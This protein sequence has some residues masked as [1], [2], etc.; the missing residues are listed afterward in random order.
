MGSSKLHLAGNASA[1]TL[2]STFQTL[3]GGQELADA[4][5]YVESTAS[6]VGVLTPEFVGQKC[7]DTVNKLI[8]FATALT[9]ADWAIMGNPVLSA[10]ELAFLDG[11]TAGTP[12][13][14]KALVASAALGVGAFRETGRNLR[15]QAAPAAKTTTTTLT[16]AEIMGG[17]ITGNQG[18]A[19]SASYTLPLGTDLE[20]AMIAAYPGLANDDSFD[21]SVVNIS[22]NANEDITVVGNTGTTLVGSG[23]VAS[24]AAA[25]DLSAGAFRVRRTATNT[26]S[27][28]R[29]G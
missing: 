16:A 4:V 13:A 20:T 5:G 6:P 19:G 26:Y 18:G 28:Y 21:F 29:I 14:S 12:V 23:A 8:Y 22:T 3:L 27:I 10:S 25:T 15:T 11:A 9:S 7:F 1:R 17:L 2:K 24:N